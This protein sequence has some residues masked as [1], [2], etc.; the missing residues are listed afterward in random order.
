MSNNNLRE[1]F[2]NW[3]VKHHKENGMFPTTNECATYWLSKLKEEREEMVKEIEA[4]KKPKSTMP[5]PCPDNMSG[6][7]VY[8]Y[9]EIEPEENK[10]IDLILQILNNKE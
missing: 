5:I 6:C 4:L 10:I 3:C 7:C 9:K 2:S 8:H 1:E